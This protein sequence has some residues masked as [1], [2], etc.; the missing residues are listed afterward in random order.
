M[1]IHLLAFL[2]KAQKPFDLWTALQ[3]PVLKDPLKWVLK[4]LIE[5]P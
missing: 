3:I 1:K 4:F 5:N 2:A